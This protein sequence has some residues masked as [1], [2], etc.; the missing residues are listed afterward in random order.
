MSISLWL[1]LPQPKQCHQD[2]LGFPSSAWI[3]L[4]RASTDV[5]ASPDPPASTAPPSDSETGAKESSTVTSDVS[6]VGGRSN[7][8]GGA[9]FPFESVASDGGA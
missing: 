8:H 9:K 4:Q 3:M 7:H 6:A 2:R 5:V 1:I